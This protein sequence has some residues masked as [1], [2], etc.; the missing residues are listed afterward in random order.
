MVTVFKAGGPKEGRKRKQG[1]G[2]SRTGFWTYMERELQHLE[3][4]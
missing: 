2:N 4:K 3:I 1:S